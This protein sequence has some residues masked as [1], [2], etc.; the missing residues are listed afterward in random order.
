MRIILV[1]FLSIVIL[2]WFLILRRRSI[3][4]FGFCAEKLWFFGFG[5]HCVLRIFRYLAFSFWISLKILT[6][7][8]SWYPIWLSGFSYLG[9]GFSSMLHLS[10][11]YGFACGFL[12]RSNFLA[13]LRSW[14]IFS[15]VLRFV[16]DDNAP[17]I[18]TSA[19][20]CVDDCLTSKNCEE[21]F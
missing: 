15:M 20:N 13:V 21:D 1:Y 2:D 10:L 6:G 17:L 12:F 11:L 8:Q 14:I 5:V 3:G 19:V 9:S 7:F 18:K 16:V 4:F